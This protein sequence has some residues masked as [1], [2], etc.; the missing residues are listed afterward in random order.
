MDESQGL[1]DPSPSIETYGLVPKTHST[2]KLQTHFP[3]AFIPHMATLTGI[4]YRVPRPLS[5]VLE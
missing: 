5:N 1:M 3:T 2:V 4:D